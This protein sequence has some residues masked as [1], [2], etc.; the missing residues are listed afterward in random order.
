MELIYQKIG[1]IR[2]N[3]FILSTIIEVSL[4]ITRNQN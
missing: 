1:R 2:E 4:K 3:I